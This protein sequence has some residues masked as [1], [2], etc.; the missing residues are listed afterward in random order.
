MKLVFGVCVVCHV[1]YTGRSPVQFCL[2]LFVYCFKVAARTRLLHTCGVY[3]KARGVS[4]S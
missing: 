2:G 1:A 3:H 4:G